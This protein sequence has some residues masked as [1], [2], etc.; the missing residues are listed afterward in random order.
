[1]AH[2]P[3]LRDKRVLIT[4]GATGIGEAI[5]K[6]FVKQGCA[7][8][9]LDMNGAAG[10]A[11]AASQH[12][13]FERC[14]LT[15]TQALQ[16][17]LSRLQDPN[18]FDVLVNNAARDDRHAIEAVTPEF[19]DATIAVNVKH[20]FFVAQAI[21]EKMRVR[22]GGSIVNISSET[23]YSG[24]TN[25]S[26]Y[27]AAKGACLSLTRSQARHWGPDNIRVNA[28]VPGWVR[29]QRQIDRWINPEAEAKQMAMQAVKRWI[30]PEDIANMVVFLA[31]EEA[32]MCSAQVFTVDAGTR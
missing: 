28:V 18:G 27:G 3:S 6:G 1:M 21:A 29:T 15:D 19:W 31:S 9:F 8:V 25:L 5:V 26:V 22:G 11:L 4:G 14:D 7:V 20:Y 10:V 30:E 12:C 32:K 2:Y 24:H 16:S 13:Q 17:L 23:A